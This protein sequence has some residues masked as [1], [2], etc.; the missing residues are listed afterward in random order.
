MLVERN[1]A[2]DNGGGLDVLGPLY[3]SNGSMVGDTASIGGG[4]ARVASAAI[5]NFGRWEGNVANGSQGGGLSCQPV[6]HDG[7]P[8]INNEGKGGGGAYVNGPAF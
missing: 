7:P 5:L 3:M 2:N 1:H 6:H 4:G 8:V